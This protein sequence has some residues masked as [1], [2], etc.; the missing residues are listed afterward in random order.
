MQVHAGVYKLKLACACM[1]CN[2][3]DQWGHTCIDSEYGLMDLN[4]AQASYMHSTA[5]AE[6]NPIYNRVLVA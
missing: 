3:P 4:P 1:G 5:L 2:A 6:Q